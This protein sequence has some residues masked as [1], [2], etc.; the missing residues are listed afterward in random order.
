MFWKQYNLCGKKEREFFYLHSRTQ[1]GY[2]TAD[3]KS[4]RIIDNSI[5][6]IQHHIW[7]LALSMGYANFVDCE[8]TGVV[9]IMMYIAHA[10]NREIV[11]QVDENYD[12]APYELESS[13]QRNL[14]ENPE[15]NESIMYV[16]D[17]VK[18][19]DDILVESLVKE[20]KKSICHDLDI[21]LLE[22]EHML[23]VS[24]VEIA[25]K[26]LQCQQIQGDGNCFSRAC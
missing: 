26:K 13:C 12:I 6:D 10:S 11:V 8:I 3:R 16:S 22:R 9:C 20:T 18:L 15:N 1:E 14:I 4:I 23:N 2:Q 5:L 25:G 21:K 19:S 24:T 17:E 7:S